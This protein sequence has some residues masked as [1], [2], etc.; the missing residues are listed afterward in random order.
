[1]SRLVLILVL[2]AVVTAVAAIAVAVISETGER[3]WRAMG[4]PGG[5]LNA[6]QRVAYVLM[7]AVMLGTATG[8]LEAG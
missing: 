5:R 4:R 6:V 7:M 8:V 3:T 1:M 2:V